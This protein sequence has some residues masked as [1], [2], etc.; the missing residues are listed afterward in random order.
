M[1]NLNFIS[2]FLS[3]LAIFFAFYLIRKIKKSPPGSEKMVEISEAIREG[4]RA[5][6][7]REFKTMALVLILIG[8]GLGLI[9]KSSHQVLTFFIG[10]IVSS[11][12]GYLGMMISTQANVR[13][14]EASRTS[15]SKGFQ[16][17]FSSGQVMGFLV[18]GLGLLGISLIW[19]LFRNINLLVSF[20]FG[21]SITALFLRVGGGIFTKSADIGADLVGKVELGIPEDDPRNPG[22][23]ADQVGDNVGDIAGMGSD[24]FESYVDAII[25]SSVIGLVAFGQK[26]LFLPLLL[27]GAG[28]LS[29]VFGSFFAKVSKDLERADFARQVAGV[30]KAM[31]RGI[32]VANLLMIFLGFLIFWKFFEE[33]KFFWCFLIGLAM[34]FLIGKVSEYYTSG[35]KKPVFGIARASQS[36][37][38]VLILEGIATEIFGIVLPVLGVAVA[39]VLVYSLGGLYGI[40]IA[41]LGVLAVLGIN[42]SADCYGPIADNSA[43]IAEM[44]GLPPEVRQKTEVLDAVG[45]TTAATGKGF[46]IGS[47]ALVALAWL[48]AFFQKANLE[49]VNLSE[50]KVL[51]SLFIGAMISFLFPALLIKGVSRGALETVKEVRRQFK[52][53][54]GLKEGRGRPEYGR[55][56]DLITKISLREMLLPG[57]L[58]ILIPILI[59]YFLGAEGLAGFLAGSLIVG[60]PLALI[61]ANTGGA[62]DNAK[63][64]IEAGNLGGKGSPAHQAAVIGDTVGDP[65]KDTAGPAI[66]ILIKLI[67]KVALISLPLF[68]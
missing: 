67:G 42:L 26:G 40:A 13:T 63:K 66:N 6:L 54:S 7:K 3:L 32:L 8:F 37:P 58:I 43:G 17:A 33:T 57:F 38:P 2:I 16:I 64:Y 23:I 51:A 25:S 15:F 56:I 39:M 48:A 12:A 10:A 65:L 21:S 31:S 68:L 53:I 27:A 29:S 22:V 41:G 36:G 5:F 47:A 45:N 9:T 59:G 52:E 19:F 34:G 20:A 1:V 35:D 46:A 24:L 55:C 4:A 61:M 30:E 62:W 14:T 60:F 11:L 28:I 49:I 50:P 18:V 44:A